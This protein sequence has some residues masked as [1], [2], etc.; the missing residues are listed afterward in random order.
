[1]SV[2]YRNGT[3]YGQ[4]SSGS[5]SGGHTIL[6]AEGTS[7]DQREKLKFVGMEVTD[8]SENDTTVVEIPEMTEEDIQDIKDAFTPNT[9]APLRMMNYSTEE[10]VV[11]TWINGKPLYQKCFIGNLPSATNWQ[12]IAN[13]KIDNVDEI[14]NINGI[15]K[16]NSDQ[17]QNIPAYESSQHFCFIIYSKNYGIRVNGNGWGLNGAVTFIVRYTKTTDTVDTV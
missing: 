8:D 2:I 14:T 11:G 4:E 7:L 10:Q 3:Y 15:A 1:M 6:D 17:Y 13:T 12:T 5:G 16:Y 9:G